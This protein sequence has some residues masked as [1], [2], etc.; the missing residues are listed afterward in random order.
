[1]IVEPR[2]LFMFW[3]VRASTLKVFPGDLHIRVYDITDT[4]EQSIGAQF[5]FD[6]AAG[7]RIGSLYL[8]VL[9]GREYF[10]DIGIMY[11]DIFITIARSKKVNTPRGTVLDESVLPSEITEA[12][13]RI[14]Y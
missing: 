14:G 7:E 2:K 1:M 8:D 13:P 4:D 11:D 10:A 9:P 6:V 5:Y 3:E 12:G